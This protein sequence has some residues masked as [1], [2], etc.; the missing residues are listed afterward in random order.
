VQSPTN[1]EK[2]ASKKCCPRKQDYADTLGGFK[3]FWKKFSGEK[4]IKKKGM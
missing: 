4:S 3:K 1:A 2:S